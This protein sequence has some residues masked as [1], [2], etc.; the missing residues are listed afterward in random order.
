MG[1]GVVRTGVRRGLHYDPD[2]YA[3]LSSLYHHLSPSSRVDE[4]L[5]ADYLRA[6][7]T[8]N[9]FELAEKADRAFELGQYQKAIRLYQKAIDQTAYVHS[10]ILAL[11]AA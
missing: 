6:G 4:Q 5:A 9:P 8:E 1:R 11:P 10:F 7:E 3:L 2:N